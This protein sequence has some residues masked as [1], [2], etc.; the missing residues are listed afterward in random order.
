MITTN[1]NVNLKVSF[2]IRT[3]WETFNILERQLLLKAKNA[4]HAAY[5]PYSKFKVG[6]AVLLDNNEIIIGNN[7]ENATYPNGLCAERVA[8]FNAS[9]N[10]PDQQIVAI[11]LCIDY[12]GKNIHEPVF[13]C[14]SCRQSILEYEERWSNNI[15]LY[16]IGPKDEVVIINTVKDILP[17]AFSGDYLKHAK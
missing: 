8:L 9:S 5:A 14:G 2:T 15:K 13:P 12:K 4:V 17:L 16:V 6:A 10:Y 11:A 3:N 1:Q 7:Q